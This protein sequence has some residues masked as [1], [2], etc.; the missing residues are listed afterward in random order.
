ML[1]KNKLYNDK[2]V[3][4]SDVYLCFF[5]LYLLSKRMKLFNHI[6]LYFSFGLIFM[7]FS[8]DIFII[9]DSNGSL[10]NLK[11][12]GNI[13]K[14]KQGHNLIFFAYNLYYIFKWPPGNQDN[15]M[16]TNINK[17]CYYQPRCSSHV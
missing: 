1:K 5:K 12:P 4:I 8:N 2:G 13:Y 6:F 10:N 3:P 11:S 9:K 16:Y 17:V 7:E 14:I 15:L